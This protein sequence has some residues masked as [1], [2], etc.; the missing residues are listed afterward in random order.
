MT[1][2]DPGHLSEAQLLV[3]SVTLRAS[4]Y[5]F[6]GVGGGKDTWSDSLSLFHSNLC[7]LLGK[8]RSVMVTLLPDLKQI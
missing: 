3:L 4:T 6:V 2:S 1:S 8:V 7:S 5:A